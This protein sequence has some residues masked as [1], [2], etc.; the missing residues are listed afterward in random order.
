[1]KC[2][3]VEVDLSMPLRFLMLHWKATAE[4]NLW[5][6]LCGVETGSCMGIICEAV[7]IGMGQGTLWFL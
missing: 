5:I 2:K 1:M 4:I 7:F 3:A 6:T